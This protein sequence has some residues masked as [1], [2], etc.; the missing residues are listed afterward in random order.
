M[1]D[2]YVIPPGRALLRRCFH[3]FIQGYRRAQ[4]KFG[5]IAARADIASA[6][7]VVQRDTPSYCECPVYSPQR[8][9]R[10]RECVVG[11]QLDLQPHLCAQR[12]FSPTMDP[13]ILLLFPVP[14]RSFDSR[15][16]QGLSLRWP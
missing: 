2:F 13:G 1:G 4:T 11:T 9:G 5:R 7:P 16:N 10:R 8:P 12:Y 3:I 14:H 6:R 15:K